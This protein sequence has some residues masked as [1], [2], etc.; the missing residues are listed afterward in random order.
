MAPDQAPTEEP[1]MTDHHTYTARTN[2]MRWTRVYG[3]AL[4]ETFPVEGDL[5]D[6]LMNLLEQADSRKTKQEMPNGD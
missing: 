6:D 3:A 5:S 4:R 2:V 1:A